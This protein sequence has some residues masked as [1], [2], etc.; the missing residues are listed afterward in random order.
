VLPGGRFLVLAEGENSSNTILRNQLLREV[1]L[2]GHIIRETNASRVAEQLESRGIHSDCRKGGKQCLSAF[3]HEAIRLPNGHTLAVTGLERMMPAGTQGSQ[4][5]VDILGD[6]IV[7]LDE[8]FQV[9]GFWNGFDHLDVNRASL[10]N[11]KCKEGPGRGGCAAV[12]LASEANGWTHTNALN[13]IPSSG[14]FLMSMPE[15]NWVVKVDYRNG[16]GSGKVIWRLGKEGDFTARSDDPYPWFSYQH[17]AGFDPVGSNIL[18]LLDNGYARHE[19]DSTAKTRG[20]VWQ[21]DEEKRTATLVRSVNLEL[22]S[23]AV[24]S[25]QTLKN[26][27]YNF[28]AGYVDFPISPYGRTVEADRDGRIVFA[29][30]LHGTLVYRSFRVDD[31]YS[32]PTK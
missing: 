16:K 3:H 1:D 9:V 21:I 11:S 8:E 30:D 28:Q 15:Q 14:D 29:I 4:E 23:S 32:A 6:V 10:R 31:M 18:T 24:G 22:Y 27:G 13:Y 12:F 26:G 7:E 25:A 17:D 20:Q 19:S 5:P 2:A